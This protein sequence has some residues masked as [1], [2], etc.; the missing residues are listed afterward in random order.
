MPQAQSLYGQL[1]QNATYEINGSENAYSVTARN[2]AYSIEDAVKATGATHLDN[3]VHEAF[4]ERDL[5]IGGVP[6]QFG[7]KFEALDK[8]MLEAERTILAAD[9]HSLRQK[10][11]A[12]FAETD[13]YWRGSGISFS[14]AETI[15]ASTSGASHGAGPAAA[16][17]GM[18]RTAEEGAN[19]ARGFIRGLMASRGGKIAA[20]VA[21]TTAVVGTGWAVLHHNK[22]KET[23]EAQDNG[24]S[25][26]T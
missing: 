22:K 11:Q 9:M 19:E 17:E 13:Q 7:P 3:L 18:G 4:M 8:A 6:I 23:A 20:G 14:A 26:R 25:P 10:A 5:S 24:V 2:A 21:A 16:G 15:A 12:I 1:M